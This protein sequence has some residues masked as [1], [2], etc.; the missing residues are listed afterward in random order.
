M[1]ILLAYAY[2]TFGGVERV[3]LNRVEAFIK[4]NLD[5]QVDVVFLHDL[6]G[7]G[8]FNHY[9]QKNG[10]QQRLRV[11]VAEEREI[12]SHLDRN[13]YDA[14]FN[15]DTPNLFETFSRAKR[16]F[17]ECHTPYA[18]NR[19][20]LKRMPADISTVIVPSKCFEERIK[21]EL[22]KGV[23]THVLPNGVADA[24]Y[25]CREWQPKRFF[26]RRPVAYMARLD[27]LKNID[28][29]LDVFQRLN[30][31]DDIFF[32]I[33]GAGAIESHFI[34]KL[35][36][37]ELLEKSV[38]RSKIPFDRVPSFLALLRGHRGV[39]LSPSKGESFGMAV[40]ESIVAGVPVVASAI[41]EHRELLNSDEAFLYR[42]GQTVKASAQVAQCIDEWDEATAKL[43]GMIDKLGHERFLH[44][45]NELVRMHRLG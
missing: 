19:A 34:R 39:F 38:I 18:E 22:P 11:L 10:L 4:A 14:V 30:G 12:P 2:C 29:A 28:E 6:G 8:A 33:V 23:R 13:N 42:L 3:I 15:I 20:Y 17:V 45:W 41:D 27:R 32:I 24:F 7:L 26:R 40:A 37:L 25:H 21:R 9:L 1:K 5:V 35:E 16:Q 43:D 31:R 36:K 44:G